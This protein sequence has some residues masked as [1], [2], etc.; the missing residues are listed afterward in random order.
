MKLTSPSKHFR[1]LLHQWF[2]NQNFIMQIKVCNTDQKIISKVLMLIE[3]Q[4]ILKQVWGILGG[5]STICHAWLVAHRDGRR[6]AGLCLLSRK[7]PCA[8]VGKCVSNR[9]PWS[10]SSIA[11]TFLP[12][13]YNLRKTS[14]PICPLSSQLVLIPR[15]G[16]K[17]VKASLTQAGPYR[18]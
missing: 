11:R 12:C 16:V 13:G 5:W 18:L 2:Q 9:P 3:F 4:M 17:A 6:E 15:P 8:C 7:N 14:L 10:S 1:I